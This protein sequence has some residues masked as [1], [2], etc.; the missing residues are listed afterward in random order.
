M[1]SLKR[2]VRG[3]TSACQVARC[4]PT[5]ARMRYFPFIAANKRLSARSNARSAID[6][7]A[8]AV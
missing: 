7:H 4:A 8:A 1:S 2:L 6:V 3:R 5:S